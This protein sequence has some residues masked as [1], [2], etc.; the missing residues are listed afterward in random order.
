M[1]KSRKTIEFKYQDVEAKE[2]TVMLEGLGARCVQHEIDHFEWYTV[3]AKNIK[4]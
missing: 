3:L 2:H 1:I 4:T